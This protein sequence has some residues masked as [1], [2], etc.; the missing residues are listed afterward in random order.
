M[1]RIFVVL[2]AVFI[3]ISLVGAATPRKYRHSGPPAVFYL[4]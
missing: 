2:L 4:Y 3:D 1:S